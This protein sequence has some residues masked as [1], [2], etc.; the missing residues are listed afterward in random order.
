MLNILWAILPIFVLI[1]LGN[2]LRRNGIPSIEFWNLNDKLVY[3]VLFPS[4]LF[5]KT[6]TTDLAGGF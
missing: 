6:S 5:Y 2:L 3:W 4:L 1:V